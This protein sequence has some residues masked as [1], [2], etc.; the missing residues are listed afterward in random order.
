MV[1]FPQ[2][3]TPN[4]RASP[5]S[6]PCLLQSS[7]F[8]L[9][10]LIEHMP[11]LT[12]LSYFSLCSVF[13]QERFNCKH[14]FLRQTAHTPDLTLDARVY[15]QFQ[16]KLSPP[17]PIDFNVTLFRI[18]RIVY[19]MHFINKGR[20]GEREK[21]GIGRKWLIPAEHTEF[22]LITN[23]TDVLERKSSAGATCIHRHHRIKVS[24]VCTLLL[25][26]FNFVLHSH[27]TSWL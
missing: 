21:D 18:A 5:C 2:V 4:P 3:Y 20:E 17:K 19:K 12:S 25:V 15:K 10:F 24:Y 8:S 9:L 1:R 16:E 23:A 6:F 11:C 27:K 14:C 26:I 22:L 13:L 7:T